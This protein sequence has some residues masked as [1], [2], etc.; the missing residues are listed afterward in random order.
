MRVGISAYDVAARDLVDLAQAADELGFSSLW[1]GEHVV[2]PVGYGSEHPSTEGDTPQ[3][4]TGPIIDPDT[5][6]VDPLVALAAAAAVTRDIEL[7]TGIYLLPLRP[8]LVTARMTATLDEVS[9]GRLV[10]GVG[11]GWLEEEFAA[12][13]VPF[14]ERVARF[15]ESIEIL[16]AAWSGRPFDHQG[17]FWQT[18]PVQVGTRPV[19][20]PLILGGN[21]ERALARAASRGDG[22]FS[23]G[24]PSFDEALRLR[25]RLQELRAAQDRPGP[26]RITMRANAPDR[27]ELDRYERAGFEEV[28]VWA[29]QVWPAEGHPDDKRAALAAAAERLGVGPRP[30]APAQEG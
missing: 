22:W 29:D 18:G 11:S 6:L 30:D 3:H 14:A 25:D 10:L 19:G 4:H 27:D 9:G 15:E 8:P 17:R 23:S 13:G 5:A 24:T 1:L 16:R 21:G 2:L 26:F 7:A 12:V 28:V 20:V